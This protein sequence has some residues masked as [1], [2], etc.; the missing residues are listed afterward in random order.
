MP[1]IY[2]HPDARTGIPVEGEIYSAEDAKRL[3]GQG[4]ATRRPP[5]AKPSRDRGSAKRKP[6]VK[7]AGEA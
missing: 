2:P 1:R 5:V 6:A 7:P 4:I 3:I